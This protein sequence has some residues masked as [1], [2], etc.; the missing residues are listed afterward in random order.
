LE[1][2]TGQPRKSTGGEDG[3]SLCPVF[4]GAETSSRG[5]LIS[6]SIQGKFAI[7]Q[8]DWKLCLSAGSGGWSAPK[9]N[10]AAEQGLP[11]MQLFNLKD[12]LGEQVNLLADHPEKVAALLTL[13]DLQI[14]N[15]RCTPGQPVAN[16][17]E[18]EFLP[19]GVTLPAKERNTQ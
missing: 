1:E 3:F 19:K 17:R 18:I 15:G 7:R 16:D 5:T 9:E 6:H 13:L 4:A 11:S 10:V 14:Q 8:G 12:D 2:I